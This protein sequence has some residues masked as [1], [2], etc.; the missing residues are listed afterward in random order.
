MSMT[1][2]YEHWLEA[3]LAGLVALGAWVWRVGRKYQ[4][5]EDRLT[6]L[7]AEAAEARRQM[8]R[9]FSRLDEIGR[10]QARHGGQI[11]HIAESTAEIR[12]ALFDGRL[13]GGRRWNDQP[14]REL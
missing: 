5:H 8:E 4:Q 2:E 3:G 14:G 13:T 7:E 1:P 12:G 11:D 9:L 6:R 10:E